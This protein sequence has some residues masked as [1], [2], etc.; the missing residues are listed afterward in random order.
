MRFTQQQIHFSE[1][2]NVYS[3]ITPLERTLQ[4]A[5]FRDTV[6]PGKENRMTQ[7]RW[8]I[9]L[10]ADEPAQLVLA[11]IAW[12]LATGASEVHLFLDNPSDPVA[13][14]AAA[15]P[16]VYVT[17]CDGSYWGQR[18]KGRPAAQTR[19]QLIN[20]DHAMA[21]SDVDWLAH[22]DAD[23]FLV[24]TTPLSRELTALPKGECHFP[25]SERFYHAGS[26]PQTI[27]DGYLRRPHKF[28]RKTARQVFG[29]AQPFLS[30]GVIGH[31]AGKSAAP[32]GSD[33]RLGIH[34]GYRGGRKPEHKVA[35]H[36]SLST[37]VY[38]FDGLTPLH[39]L[40]KLAR[41]ARA[42]DGGHFPKGRLAQIDHFQAH[43]GDLPA[44][45]AF[46][47]MLRATSVETE[48]FLRKTGLSEPAPFDPSRQIS[49]ILGKDLDL[50]V[51]AFDHALQDRYPDLYSDIT[52]P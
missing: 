48:T 34:T 22:V 7:T 45:M 42:R 25:V 15:L 30:A 46:H 8:G 38:H 52:T 12:H 18:R 9:V 13:T 36:R 39:F 23:E 26:A 37:R 14:D 50:S 31:R 24:Q 33:Y 17:L 40:L 11:N 29:A 19:R 2:N 51:A 28:D 6:R 20:T 49:A 32:T 35:R 10:T 1:F 47:D 4:D 41:Y 21:R 43:A 3:Q 44:L 5:A 27:F 16:G